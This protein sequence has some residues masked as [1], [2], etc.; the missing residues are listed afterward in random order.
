M[1]Q[2][3]AY[4][5]DSYCDFVGNISQCPRLS[6]FLNY[7]FSLVGRTHSTTSQFHAMC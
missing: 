5:I 2:Q 1:L 4:Q 7:G 6:L 3:Y